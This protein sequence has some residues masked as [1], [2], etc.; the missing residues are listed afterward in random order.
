MKKFYVN[1]KHH[2]E[3]L[4]I[5]TALISVSMIITIELI[6]QKTKSTELWV[7]LYSFA[8]S[9][10][11]LVGSVASMYLEKLYTIRASIWYLNICNIIGC[12]LSL[13]GLCAVF[14]NFNT[15]IGVIFLT[16]SLFVFFV[17][18]KYTD[19]LEKINTEN[20]KEDDEVEVK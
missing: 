17:L 20:Q 2:R 11:L 10:P 7:A 19:L 15:I 18:F 16:T 4:L 14:F 5:A 1:E 9:I 12:L 13:V 8:I 6:N 3:N